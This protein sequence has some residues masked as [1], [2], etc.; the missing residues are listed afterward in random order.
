MVITSHSG[1][2]ENIKDA[3]SNINELPKWKE[4]KYKVSENAPYNPYG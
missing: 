4:K 1:Y 3:F 2:T